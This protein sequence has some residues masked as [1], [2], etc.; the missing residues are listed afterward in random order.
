MFENANE[1]QNNANGAIPLMRGIIMGMKGRI[2]QTKRHKT[3]MKDIIM[4]KT[5]EL[6]KVKAIQHE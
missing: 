2:M 4:Q 3:R 6:F 5:G 1:R